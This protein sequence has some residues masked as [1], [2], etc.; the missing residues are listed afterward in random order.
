MEMKAVARA[1]RTYPAFAALGVIG[2][3]SLACTGAVGSGSPNSSGAG[4]PGVIGGGGSSTTGGANS[5]GGGTGAPVDLS[6]GGPRL[7]VLTQLEYKNSVN[8]LLG[9][10]SAKLDLP[11]DTFLSGFTSIGGAEVAIN[12]SAV[13]PYETASLA[14]AGE[15]FADS[16]R[17]QKLVGCQP[18][19]DLSDACITTF[20]Q[21]FGKR[22]FRRELTEAEVQQWLKIGRDA[23]Q[24]PESSA[25][26]GLE[27][28]VSGLL[29]SPYF[30]YRIETNKLDV[31]S[32][33][34]KYDGLSMATRLSFLLTGHPPSDALLTA[35]AAGQL[36]TAD[37]IKTAAA[38]LLTDAS[39]VDRMAAFF[40]EYA[41]S[42]LVLGSQKSA[43]M[44][45]TYNAALQS[46][47][48]QATELFIKNVVLAPATDVRTI[49][50]SDQTFVD[51]NLAPLY[52]VS[53][54]AS[55]F[56]Q[57]KLPAEAG[58]AG[59]FGQAGVVAGHSA[60]DRSSPTRRGV[61][62]LETFLCTTPPPPPGG[63]NTNLVVDTTQ[64]TRQQL[65][66]HRKDPK[67]A[68]CHALF[69]PLGMGMEHLDP[70]GK[71]RATENG[72][73]IDATG[74]LDGVNFDGALQLG[75]AFRQSTRAMTCMMS[76][77]YRAANGRMVAE[78]DLAEI[79]KLTQTL[80][81]KGY[82]WRDLVAEFVASDAFRSA[83]AAPV[84]AGNQ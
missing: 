13:E 16:A 24:L 75:A 77:F 66:A 63:V 44:F 36:D 32:G 79:D 55:G 26:K 68:S 14:A 64:T 3:C 7:R 41:Q 67:C 80:T 56:M 60:A 49:F 34:L 52:G 37:G 70:I 43:T 73:A 83:P 2:L 82:V 17:W 53:A 78:P 45:P 38:P 1:S 19:A 39:A 62:L 81:A 48:F 54:P 71:Y 5:G 59:I 20:V 6:K 76:N 30:L 23:A 42:S 69:D 8:D 84:T 4:S 10:I 74:S 61:F 58:R 31:A 28:L 47:M 15:V 50:D 18:K 29:Q 40:S 21:T 27:T 46:S 22:A 35:A 33:R 11:A 51:A 25:A 57:I 72:A 12:A 65:E 9:P